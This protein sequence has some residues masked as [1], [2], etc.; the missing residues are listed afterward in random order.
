V[1]ISRLRK[2]EMIY[3]RKNDADLRSPERRKTT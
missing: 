3:G 2:L 1:T